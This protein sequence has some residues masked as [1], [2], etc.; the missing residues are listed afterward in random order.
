M[1]PSE[2]VLGFPG[3]F[4]SAIVQHLEFLAEKAIPNA[5]A[6][7]AFAAIKNATCPS[8]AQDSSDSCDN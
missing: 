4:L 5:R 1:A 2:A 7:R 6:K 3:R 8:C